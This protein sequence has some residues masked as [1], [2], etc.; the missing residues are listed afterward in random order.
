VAAAQLRGHLHARLALERESPYCVVVR[1]L[2]MACASMCMCMC[3]CMHTMCMHTLINTRRVYGYVSTLSKKSRIQSVCSVNQSCRLLVD[4]DDCAL[5]LSLDSVTYTRI[6][7]G[8]CEKSNL[9][10]VLL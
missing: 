7:A 10:C 1:Y 6:S 5:I 8:G 9:F 3:M 4:T 2:R